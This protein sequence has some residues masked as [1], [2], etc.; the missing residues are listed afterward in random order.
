MALSFPI[1]PIVIL[2]LLFQIRRIC[3]MFFTLVERLPRLPKMRNLPILTRISSRV[4]RMSYVAPTLHDSLFTIHA[5]PFATCHELRTMNYE[6]S[7]IVIPLHS[8][9]AYYTPKTLRRKGNSCHRVHSSR[10][11]RGP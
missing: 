1:L 4:F 9:G 2:A 10:R 5:W 6:L 8:S 3:Q 7:Y 11:R